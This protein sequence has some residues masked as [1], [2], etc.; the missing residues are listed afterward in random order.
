MRRSEPSYAAPALLE[1]HL[2]QRGTKVTMEGGGSFRPTRS[3]V[4]YFYP[5]SWCMKHLILFW[6]HRGFLGPERWMTQDGKRPFNV[7]L[8][9]ST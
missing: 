9:P 2:S 6:C 8:T 1:P 5:A 4:F 3:S 7:L